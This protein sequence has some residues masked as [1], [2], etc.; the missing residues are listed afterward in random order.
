MKAVQVL[1]RQANS[2]GLVVH[3]QRVA[4]IA[5]EGGHRRITLLDRIWSAVNYQR[6]GKPFKQLVY[7]LPEVDEENYREAFVQV[8]FSKLLSNW[9]FEKLDPLPAS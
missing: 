3:Y 6:I 8:I 7:R 1:H 9:R 4:L 2:A 5:L